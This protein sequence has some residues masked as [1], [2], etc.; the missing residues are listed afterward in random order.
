M[1]LYTSDAIA[2]HPQPENF[3][4]LSMKSKKERGSGKV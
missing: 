4:S 3:T 2:L 1:I